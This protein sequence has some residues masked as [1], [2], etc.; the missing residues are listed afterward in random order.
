MGQLHPRD[1]SLKD[2]V[3]RSAAVLVVRPD[4]PERLIVEV[5]VGRAPPYPRIRW[6]YLVEEVL[7]GRSDAPATGK[8]L[9]VDEAHWRTSLNLHRRYVLE[10]LSRHVVV[11]T[12]Q[13]LHPPTAGAPHLVFL[14]PG[15]DGWEYTVSGA[16]EGMDARKKVV[17]LLRKR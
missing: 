4:E 3:Q 11:E 9:E 12:Y 5:D 10:G 15:E 17:S 2:L 7:H 14:S 6:R 1:V 16:R 13:P 8:A